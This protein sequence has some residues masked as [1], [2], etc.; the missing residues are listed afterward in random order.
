M[1]QRYF[2]YPL[3]FIVATQLPP[4]LLRDR[5]WYAAQITQL[6]LILLAAVGAMIFEDDIRW[7][8]IAWGLFVAFVLAPRLLLR[9]AVR[10]M[11]ARWWTL[12]GRLVWGESGRLY[13]AHGAVLKLWQAGNHPAAEALLDQLAAREMPE[14]IRGEVRMWKVWLLT[15]AVEWPRAIACY[16]SVDS[17]GSLGMAMWARIHVARAYAEAGRFDAA[18]RCLQL[19]ALSPRTLGFLEKQFKRTRVFVLERLPAGYEADRQALAAAEAQSAAWRDLMRW[20]QPAPVTVALVALCAGIW[21]A[22]KFVFD[23]AL[24]SAA[25]NMPDAV[26][27]GEWW[28]TL[29]ALFLHANWLHLA[30]NGAALWLFGAAVEKTLG[31]WRLLV[32][33]LVA[34]GVA[35]FLSA[36]IAQYDVSVGASGGIFG[37][38]A[39]FGVAL[40]RLRSPLYATVRRRMLLVLAGAVLIDFTIGGLEPQIDNFAHAGGFVVGLLLAA[41]LPRRRTKVES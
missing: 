3:L 1:T 36:R 5:R 15:A 8:W 14:P 21:L 19:L 6:G 2:I 17:W 33:F 37:V 30:M 16:E 7:V 34:G 18:L 9:Q 13:R 10:T 24:I 29:T 20:G 25:G 22:D 12:A 26:R 39:A 40:Y 32:I 35:N 38:V 41:A 27:E 4:V 31:R 28:R 11:R 23:Y